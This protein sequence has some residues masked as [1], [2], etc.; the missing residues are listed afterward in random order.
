MSMSGRRPARRT[1][2]LRLSNLVGAAVEMRDV[3]RECR[4]T[5][6]LQ[7]SSISS[8]ASTS[9]RP[10]HLHQADDS[11]GAYRAT[12]PMISSLADAQSHRVAES[13]HVGPGK[14]EQSNARVGHASENGVR[15]DAHK[16]ADFLAV[17]F[18]SLQQA[19]KQ[20]N[21]VFIF[22]LLFFAS[23]QFPRAWCSNYNTKKPTFTNILINSI[24][25]R[26]STY[27]SKRNNTLFYLLNCT[28]PPTR[29]IQLQ[30]C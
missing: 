19:L 23:N 13:G 5:K 16:M 28:F 2:T 1:C 9:C 12:R 6:P 27:T 8:L 30:P 15:M 3:G 21:S 25:R 7:S 24:S 11:L 22:V 20:Q 29:F 18:L 10:L 14:A 26:R 17:F 4:I